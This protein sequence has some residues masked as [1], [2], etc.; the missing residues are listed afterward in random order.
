MLLCKVH[1][2]IEYGR[3]SKIFIKRY[4]YWKQDII[5]GYFKQTGPIQNAKVVET[6][7]IIKN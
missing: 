4:I 2:N 7:L 3:D 1:C 6:G 5:S